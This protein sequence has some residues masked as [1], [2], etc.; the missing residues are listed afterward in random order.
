MSREKQYF[1]HAGLPRAASTLLQRRVFPFLEGI[2]Y[3]KRRLYER[4]TEIIHDSSAEKF[5]FTD[6]DIVRFPERFSLLASEFPTAR[7]I[8]VL[9]RQDQWVVSRYKY[10]IRKHGYDSFTRFCDLESDAGQIRHEHL[11]FSKLLQRFERTFGNQPF[12]LLFDELVQHPYQAVGL[13]VDYLGVTCEPEK[14]NFSRVNASF[15]HKQLV[16]LRRFNQLVR[17]RES[18]NRRIRKLKRKL[19]GAALH[20]FAFASHA[21][22]PALI[23]DTN[24][25]IP[26][27]AVERI[28]HTYAE[29]WQACLEYVGRQ[30]KLLV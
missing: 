4:K 25:L 17:Y 5:L 27:D 28:R 10:S 30:R 18:P 7:P 9:R 16:A 1:V 3:I 6:E 29:D 11:A 14:L 22:P 2:H 20:T 21:I 8:L 19:F 24:D 15:S 13:L 26:R 12:V 23:G